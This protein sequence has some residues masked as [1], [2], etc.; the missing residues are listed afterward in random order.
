[1]L[2]ERNSLIQDSM[3]EELATSS[4][5]SNVKVIVPNNLAGELRGN[6]ERT[7][8]SGLFTGSIR[9]AENPPAGTSCL[10][11]GCEHL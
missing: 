9:I 3:I 4:K 2:L 10:V 11:I 7:V 6:E 8:A 1:M 5:Q